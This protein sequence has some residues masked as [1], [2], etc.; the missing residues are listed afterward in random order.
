MKGILNFDL[1]NSNIENKKIR[2]IYHEKEGCHRIVTQRTGN[3][4]P[5]T[6]GGC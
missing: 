5:G 2:G 3:N 4:I 1:Q 6:A